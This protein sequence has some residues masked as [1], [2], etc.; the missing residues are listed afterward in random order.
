MQRIL[1]KKEPKLGAKHEAFAYQSEAFKAVRDR[2]YA[3]IFHEQGLGKTKIAIDLMLYWLENKTVDTVLIVVKKSLL[4]NWQNELATHTFI[5]PKILTQNRGAN[6]HV[7]NSP[8]RVLLTHYEVLKGERER[9]KIF[10]KTRR[11]GIILDESARIKNPDADLTKS[12]IELAPGFAKRIIMTGTPIANRPHDIWSQICFLDQGSSLG[13]DF[14]AF[15]QSVPLSNELGGNEKAQREFETNIQ[16]IYKNISAFTVRENKKSGVISLP[17]KVIHS[18]NTDWEPYQLDLY[19]QVR[20]DL[21]AIVVKDGTPTEDNS[22]NLL[23]RLLRLVQ[24]ASNPRLIDESYTAEPG[25]LAQLKDLVASI[26]DDKEKSIVWTS[27][28]EN[29]VWIAKEL[30]Q[31]GVRTVRGNMSM[32]ARNRSIA[33]FLTDP[34]TGVLVATPGA[35]K[36]GLTLTVAN[37]V[38]F[39]DR[40]FGLDDYLQAQDRIHRISQEK[41]CH[42]HNLIMEDS[43]DEWIDVLLRAKELAAQLGQGDISLS[44]YKSHMPYDFGEILKYILNIE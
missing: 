6:Y 12:F 4:Q 39:Y 37:H 21:R 26:H 41:T 11:V 30:S 16:E 42:V 33:M 35:A 31:F 24:V 3:A 19:T 43:I 40:G 2:E 29:V 8:S 38:I 27:F 32:D 23:K 7:F 36:E 28:T 10:L 5:K 13:V 1:L 22:D 34:D 14:A 9:M 17:E 20:D 44:Y 15:K 18:V 25:K